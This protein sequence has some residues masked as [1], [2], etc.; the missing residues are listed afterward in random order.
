M[1]TPLCVLTSNSVQFPLMYKINVSL[2][3]YLPNP[4]P[5]MGGSFVTDFKPGKEFKGEKEEK[6][7]KGREKEEGQGKRRKGREK[8][9]IGREKGGKG[10]KE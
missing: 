3:F 1:A 10:R 5:L 4:P 8:G 6:V 2:F 9:R 7:E